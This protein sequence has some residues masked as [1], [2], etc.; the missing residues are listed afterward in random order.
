MRRTDGEYALPQARTGDPRR[1]TMQTHIRRDDAP[2]R[3]GVTIATTA[4]HGATMT[5]N[6]DSGDADNGAYLQMPRAFLTSPLPSFT[7]TIR[8]EYV[9]I[10]RTLE[11]MGFLLK[12]QP[13]GTRGKTFENLGGL[14]NK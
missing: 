7:C 9:D 8:S 12:H 14:Q 5:M 3:H 4:H 13:I 1:T 2:W 6:H 11:C 10:L